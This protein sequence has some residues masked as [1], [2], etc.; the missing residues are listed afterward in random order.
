MRAEAEANAAS[1]TAKQ[2]AVQAMRWLARLRGRRMTNVKKHHLPHEHNLRRSNPSIASARPSS[3]WHHALCDSPEFD[4]SPPPDS[5]H[6][7][8]QWSADVHDP[9]LR[10]RSA[11]RR[12]SGGAGSAGSSVIVAE[13]IAPLRGGESDD[14]GVPVQRQQCVTRLHRWFFVTSCSGT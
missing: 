6:W 11:E 4:L 9:P 3:K 10:S 12:R 7:Q 8:V 2:C 5:T 13:Q 1:L 14:I